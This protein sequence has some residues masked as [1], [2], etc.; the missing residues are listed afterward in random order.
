M[1]AG[2]RGRSGRRGSREE[3]Q[4]ML[5]RNLLRIGLFLILGAAIIEVFVQPEFSLQRFL[6]LCAAAII[7]LL[8]GKV[9]GKVFSLIRRGG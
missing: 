2:G 8:T 9:I 7:G 3:R 1:D 4:R 5:N 6:F